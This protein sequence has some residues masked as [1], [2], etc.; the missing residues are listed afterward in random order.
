MNER[1]DYATVGPSPFFVSQ[2]SS[3]KFRQVGAPSRLTQSNCKPQEAENT[4]AALDSIPAWHRL[5]SSCGGNPVILG[6]CSFTRGNLRE[7]PSLEL[8]GLKTL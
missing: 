5:S 6:K 3:R 8:N 4:L 7:H 2:A 1:P